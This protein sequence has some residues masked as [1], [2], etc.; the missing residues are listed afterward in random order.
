MHCTIHSI[1][2]PHLVLPCQQSTQGEAHDVD[3]WTEQ[4]VIDWLFSLHGG[5]LTEYAM[6]FQLH[7]ITGRALFLLSGED[8]LQM[9]VLSL[10][11]RKRLLEEIEVLHRDNHRLIHFPP[12]QHQH[13]V[14][15][16]IRGQRSL[17]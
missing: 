12:L 8:L 10:G 3:Q 16:H 1:V 2:S 7:H 9:G 17:E 6:L 13:K 11:H 4:E 14:R 5:Q 15:G